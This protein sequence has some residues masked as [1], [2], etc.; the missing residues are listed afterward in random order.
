M[1]LDLFR[2]FWRCWRPLVL[3]DILFKVAATLVITPL[4]A[5]AFRA[6]VEASGREVLADEDILRFFTSPIGLVSGVLIGGVLLATLVLEQAVLLRILWTSAAGH[7]P[8][9]TSALMGAM[10]DTWTTVKLGS[11]LVASA[12]LLT[13]P[14]AILLGLVYW[15]LLTGH[16]INYYLAERPAEFWW[17]VGIGVA[18]VTA[19]VVMLGM[20]LASN[21]FAVPLVVVRRMHV[22]QS[23][24]RS[25]E[26]TRGRRW[27]VTAWL[28]GWLA[29]VIVSPWLLFAA[30]LAVG[31]WIA[32]LPESLAVL[33]VLVGLLTLVHFVLSFV[34]HLIAVIGFALIVWRL[35]QRMDPDALEATSAANVEA[36]D[37]DRQWLVWNRWRLAFAGLVGLTI[38]GIVGSASLAGLKLVDDCEIIGHR[39]GAAHAPENSLAAIR[40]AIRARA[41]WVEIDV[42]ETSDG[43]VV[44][45]HD[46]DLKR[47]AGDGGE[48]HA[49]TLEQL[50]KLDIGSRV[51]AEFK[52]EPVATLDDVLELAKGRVGVVIELKQY[53]HDDQLEQRVVDLVEKHEMANEVII[54]SLDRKMIAK[55]RELRP[56]WNIGLLTAVK[57]G[58]LTRID[59]DL[60]AVSKELATP[61]L[62]AQAHFR[63]RDVAAWTLNT[64]DS[65]DR[66][67]DRGVDYVITDDVPLAREVLAE[68]NERPLP[69]RWLRA[70]VA[71]M[72]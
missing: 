37:T 28:L 45:V 69:A 63:D 2:T 68:R 30:Y 42:Q 32:D 40:G 27:R 25:R 9:V 41:H 35:W 71:G 55:I 13:A 15:W 24:Q 48:V 67:M 47:L 62:V 59:T 46:R 1:F 57:I 4:I 64:R 58:D 54:I 65:L 17:A 10:A 60:L 6:F 19:C 66:M 49:S 11:L 52:G 16:D 53:G 20:L 50:A 12:I 14:W 44:V 51:G 26:L 5:L 36:L 33:T 22:R 56:E 34:L 8:R 29:V 61:A 21:I 7:Y 23:L 18:L 72:D 70:L 39:G 38:A 43:H 31:G 3:A